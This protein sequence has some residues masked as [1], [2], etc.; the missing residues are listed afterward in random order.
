MLGIDD[1]RIDSVDGVD[2]G[3]DGDEMADDEV[4]RQRFVGRSTPHKLVK[5]MCI[6]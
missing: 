5:N 2:D 6:I 3:V 4:V 1:E